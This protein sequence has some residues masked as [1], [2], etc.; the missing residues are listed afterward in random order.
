MHEKDPE[1]PPQPGCI[2]EATHVRPHIERLTRDTNA[3]HAQ[4]RDHGTVIEKLLLW[5]DESGR[6]LSMLE[7]STSDHREEQRAGYRRVDKEIGDLKVDLASLKDHVNVEFNSVRERLDSVSN[8]MGTLLR[9]FDVHADDMKEAHVTATRRHERLLRVGMTI[10]TSFAA[11]SAILVALHG[12]ISGVPL[13]ETLK[14]V[15]PK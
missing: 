8:G 12:A 7:Q 10:A 6:R 4:L 15:L 11:L 5:R 13:L 2:I 9:R 14:E 3:A 1:A